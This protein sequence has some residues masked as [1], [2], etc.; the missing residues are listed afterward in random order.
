G[1]A[2]LEALQNRAA[3]ALAANAVNQIAK[4]MVD[5]RLNR[6]GTVEAPV[7][8]K[9]QH[10]NYLE[11]LKRAIRLRAKGIEKMEIGEGLL[12]VNDP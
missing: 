1:K 12:I 2:R 7:S 4:R 8:I 9:L 10:L 5:R 3:I 11:A 6:A